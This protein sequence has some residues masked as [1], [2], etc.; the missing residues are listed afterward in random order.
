M[1]IGIAVER[2]GS[3]ED[4]VRRLAR[5]PASSAFIVSR[6][7]LPPTEFSDP[8]SNRLKAIF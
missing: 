8:A 1:A 3:Y 2:F 6:E 7:V 5:A 4:D